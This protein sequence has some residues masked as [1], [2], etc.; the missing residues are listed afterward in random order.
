[1]VP[2][3]SATGGVKRKLEEEPGEE[4]K[5]ARVEATS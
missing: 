5:K 4:V 1:V 2:A 3:V